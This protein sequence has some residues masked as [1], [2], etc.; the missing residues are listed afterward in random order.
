MT[1]GAHGGRPAW[2]WPLGL[3]AGLALAAANLIWSLGA[4]SLFIDEVLSWRA[5]HFGLGNLLHQVHVEE[6][7]PPT[8]FLMLHG[9]LRVLGSD[10]E[11]AMRSLSL[12]AALGTVAAAAWI[13][14]RLTGR[15]AAVLAA[16]LTAVSPLILED[17]QEAR[18]YAWA[19]FAGAVAVGAVLESELVEAGRRRWLAL[20][21]AAGV[22]A[23]WLHY[24]SMLVV[25]PLCV[26][27]LRAGWLRERERRAFVASIAIGAL[28]VSPFLLVQSREGH[29]NAVSAIAQLTSDNAKRAIGAPFDRTYPVLTHDGQ[30]LGALLVVAAVGMLLIVRPEPRVRHPR[31]LAA[32]AAFAPLSLLLLTAIG[33][34]VLISRYDAV[35]VPYM[36]IALATGAVAFRVAGSIVAALALLVAAGASVDA[37][38]A[39]YRYPDTRAAMESVASAWRPGDVLLPFRGYPAIGDQLEYYARRLLPAGARVRYGVTS[40]DVTRALATA[41]GVAIVSEPLAPLPAAAQVIR[42]AGMR[43]DRAAEVGG[44]ARLQSFVAHRGAGR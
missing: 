32:L 36:A 4:S 33:P 18:P 39:R 11:A 27:V 38:R 41:P 9:W 13:A 31:L 28:L 26:F 15:T 10:S 30:T 12:L 6:V 20:G 29:Q 42:R 22:A 7:S 24:T 21:A 1:P 43:V 16:M 40:R 19:I 14:H 34:K 44:T 37:H 17:G 5:A 8:Y 3:A 35:A 25:L 23:V 2:L